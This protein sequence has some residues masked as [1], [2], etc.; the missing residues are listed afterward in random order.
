MPSIVTGAPFVDIKIAPA[1][2]FRIGVPI[3]R[4][5]TGCLLGMRVAS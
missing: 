5:V 1:A 4:T 2:Q 3:Q